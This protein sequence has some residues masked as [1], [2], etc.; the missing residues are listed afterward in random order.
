MGTCIK[1]PHTVE[2]LSE[3]SDTTELDENRGGKTNKR[4][5]RKTNKRKKK[6]TPKNKTVNKTIRK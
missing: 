3:S 5:K 4:R 2:I 1:L 6:K